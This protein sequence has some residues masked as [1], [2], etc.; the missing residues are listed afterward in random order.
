MSLV[1][2]VRYLP[3]KYL[4]FKG[5][6]KKYILQLDFCKD[7]P[8]EPQKRVV[9]AKPAQGCARPK[10]FGLC[11]ALNSKYLQNIAQT[12]TDKVMTLT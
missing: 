9:R 12:S 7:T 11:E 2:L 5:L 6:K 1:L 8:I 3:W 10:A 4:N